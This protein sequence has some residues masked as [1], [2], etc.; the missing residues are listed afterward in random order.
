MKTRIK[1]SKI[2]MTADLKKYIELKLAALEKYLGNI[3]VINCDFEVEKM[4]GEQHKGK[5]YRAEINLELPG[6]M[7]NIEKS[8]IDIN[9]AIDKVKEHLAEMIKKYKGKKTDKKRAR[10]ASPAKRAK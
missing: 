7:L 9:K 10:L 8:A 1:A 6:E 4:A 3:P 5:I 2:E